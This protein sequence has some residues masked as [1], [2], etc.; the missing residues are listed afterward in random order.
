[1]NIIVNGE[2]KNVSNDNMKEAM[3]ELGFEELKCATALNGNFISVDDRE[4]TTL[5]EGDK[6]E[7]LSPQQGG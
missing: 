4:F 2:N 3:N 6:I 1:V 7:V 5:K